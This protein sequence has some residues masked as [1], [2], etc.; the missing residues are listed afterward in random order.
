M[1]KRQILENMESQHLKNKMMEALGD[2]K[3]TGEIRSIGLINALE[4][5]E[6]REDKKGF[7]PALRIGWQI[8]REA[9]KRGLLIRPIGDLIYFNPPLTI[10]RQEIDQAV[11]LLKDSVEAVLAK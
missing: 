6:E 8:G 5:V 11:R 3:N 10:T 2:H 9:M 1:Y 4:L 7:D